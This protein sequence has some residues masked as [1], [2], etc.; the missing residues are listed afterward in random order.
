MQVIVIPTDLTSFLLSTFCVFSNTKKQELSFPE[1]GGLVTRNVLFFYIACRV[2][3]FKPMPNSIDTRNFLT[4]YSCS[5]RGKN[6]N[7][8]EADLSDQR[9]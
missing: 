2:L 1:V 9:I 7:N 5:K 4:C 6:L 3:Y 8:F